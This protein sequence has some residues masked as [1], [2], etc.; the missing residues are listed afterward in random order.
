MAAPGVSPGLAP[1]PHG[2]VPG[3][4]GAAL[5]VRHLVGLKAR[6]LLN[7]LSRSTWVLVGT[8]VGAAY[9]LFLLV[10]SLVGLFLLGREELSL[11]RTVLVLAGSAATLAWW[12]V[13][14]LASRA[15]ATLDPARLALFPLTVGQVQW[16]QA[17]G[18]L[19]GVPGALTALALAGTVL[20]W[21]SSAAAVLTA[22]VC[23]PLA[24]ALLFT[25]SRCVTALAIGLSRRRR[26][27]ELLSV[28]AL[29][30]L[31][32]LGPLFAGVL[33]GLELVWERLPEYAAALAWTPLGAVWA[34]PADV[35]AGRWAAAAARL[36]VTGLT[37]LA[38]VLLWRV[39]QQRAL[40][41]AAG[42]R[43][44]ATGGSDGAGLL[45]R[46]PPRPWAAVAARCLIYWIRDPRYSAGLLVI[47]A[48][49]VLLWLTR[50]PGGPN[51][52]FHALGPM[53]AA[54]MAYTISADVSSDNTAVHLHLLT[55]L[56]GVHDR[57]GR[58]LALLVVAAPLAALGLLL[59]LAVEGR[60]HLL[61]GLL[62]TTVLALLG[63]CGLASVM[64]ARYTYPVAPP[65]A[66][67]LKTPEGFTVLN[68]LVQ[69]VALA[70][71]LLLTLPAA[72]PLLVHA[73][74]GS[75]GWGWAALAAGFVLGPLLCGLGVVVGGRWYDRRA[76]ELLQEVAR[77]R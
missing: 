3:R 57:A 25:G 2:P 67:P 77:F 37:V 18:A 52:L 73:A 14:V 36:A 33:S 41:S 34:L 62:G 74:G 17:L 44:A 13:P 6:I 26:L 75:A 51:V 47:P 1:A 29:V 53:V 63:G 30:G 49:A 55:G 76:P 20:A 21:R 23:L 60:W 8:V 9:F 7:T 27:T 12:L 70:L 5:P 24:L 71:M 69:F 46:L 43:A 16:G 66:S 48:I 32:F 56:R 11:V 68:V 19:V 64:S 28:V 58:V 22:L 72:V 61:P 65:G 4:A 31:V 35:A 54:L 50:D 45:D 40:T 39:A 42:E 15:D 38:L 10:T 59:P